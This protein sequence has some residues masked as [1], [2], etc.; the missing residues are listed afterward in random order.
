MSTALFGIRHHGPGSAKSLLQALDRYQP[1]LIL[2]EA[3]EELIPLLDYLNLEDLRPPIAALLYNPK[4][5]QQAVYYPFAS[6]SPEWQAFQWAH[7]QSVPVWA[8]DLPQAMRLGLGQE[9]ERLEA[10]EAEETKDPL[11]LDIARDPM[12]YLARLAGYTDSERWWEVF[13]EQGRGQAEVF[14][15]VLELMQTLRAEV[16]TAGQADNR[17]REAY[18]RKILRKAQKAGY[19]RI[20][21]VCGAWHTPALADLQ[22]YPLREDNALLKGIP[23]LKVK[24][25]WIPWTYER[26]AFSSGYGAG[27]LSPAWYSLLFEHYDQATIRWMTLVSQLFKKEDLESSAA[28]AIEGVRLAETLA[29]LRGLEM[30]GIDELTEAVLTIFSGG[31]RSQLDLVRQRLIIGDQMGE[32]PDSI[33]SI[34]LQQDLEQHITSLKLK[35]YRS[36]EA[37]WLKANSNRP[38][39]GLDLRQ[40]HDLQQSQF[41]HR[42]SLL[43]INWGT[44][45][46][47]LGT[48]LSTK[49]E[50]W[51]LQWQPEFAIRIIE[52]GMWG[53]TVEQA[54]NAFVIHQAKEATQL[55]ALTELLERVLHA[56]LNPALQV[57]VQ[58]L[59]DR[60]A[61][62]KDVQ[63]LLQ[64]L[65]ALVRVRRYGDVRQTAVQQ[66][67]WM[68]QSLIPRICI[69]LPPA[70]TQI[71]ETASSALFGQI[72]GAHRAL[73]LLEEE[74][75]WEQWQDS[76]ATLA[77]GGQIARDLSG[78]STRLLLDAQSWTVQQAAEQMRQALAKGAPI[79]EG[80]A[81][82]QGFLH[83]NGLL[84]LLNPHLWQLLD[85]WLM[86]LSHMEFQQL[87]P[88]LRKTFSN[89]APAERQ[90]MLQLARS[91]KPSLQKEQAPV[92]WDEQ[93]VQAI[94]PTLQL[95]FGEA[96]A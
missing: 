8:M 45:G 27:V 36:T 33:P 24:A 20:A 4:D 69:G 64:A 11:V 2:V 47:P 60:A 65:P 40:A 7:R 74:V 73:L 72:L 5:L 49:N 94:L 43:K 6:F 87:L 9:P 56:N 77:T 90:K 28:H 58:A 57:L 66:V 10:L 37:L 30:P 88:A 32:V 21:V 34:P 15:T 50:Y 48:E 62:V 16:G 13:F 83:G 22:A 53:N 76:L 31:Y 29:S 68:L 55:S 52:A 85:T 89:Y 59:R 95:I 17:I 93:R 71:D 12:G 35:K 41:L 81:W 61:L 82:L 92:Q 19:D 54:A 39:G 18:M 78:L 63:H 86:E 42:L 1:D 46:R 80:S 23:K 84:L 44:L 96:S 25:T 26:L 67:D 70:C 91:G 51:Q 14:D 75:Y 79:Q 3:P 38:Q